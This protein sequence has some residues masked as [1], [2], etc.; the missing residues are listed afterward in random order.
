MKLGAVGLLRPER[1]SCQ[2]DW[3]CR[4]SMGVRFH[5]YRPRLFVHLVKQRTPNA[6]VN[7]FSRVK[8]AVRNAFRMPA[9]VPAFA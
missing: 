2:L 7:A 6:T 4:D 9:F 8:D 1:R 5:S 3:G